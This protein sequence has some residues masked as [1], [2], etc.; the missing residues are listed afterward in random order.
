VSKFKVI[1]F[2]SNTQS[3]H[4]SKGP[5]WTLSPIHTFKHNLRGLT[6]QDK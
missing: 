1:K 4:C 5:P 2:K 3:F 6:C